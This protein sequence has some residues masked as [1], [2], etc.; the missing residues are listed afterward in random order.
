MTTKEIPVACALTDRELQA[1]RKDYLDRAA[2]RLIEQTETAAGF[3]FKFPLG[4]AM[5]RD[6][7]EIIYLER[8]GCPLLD[9]A[10]SLE[11]GSDHVTLA[12]GGMK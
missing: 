11:A 4:S 12:L 1:R 2:A 8:R 10:L 3:S 5:L 9:F 6:L 7:A